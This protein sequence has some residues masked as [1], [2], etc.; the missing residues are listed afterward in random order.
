MQNVLISINNQEFY[1]KAYFKGTDRDSYIPF[2]SCHHKPWVLKGTKGV[3][4]AL[5]CPC[6]LLN[7]GR[8]KRL[9][10][11]RIEEHVRNIGKGCDKH[12]LYVNFRDVHNKEIRGLQFWGLEALKKQW[13]GRNFVRELSKRES[14]WIPIGIFN[15]RGFEYRF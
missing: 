3:V 5:K 12:H 15:A 9:L 7:I 13:R 14:W 6:N 1:T 2:N 10:K 4:Y 8:T 11:K